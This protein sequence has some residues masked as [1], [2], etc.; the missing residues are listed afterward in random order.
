MTPIS[1]PNTPTHTTQCQAQEWEEEWK[2]ITPP[3]Q[4]PWALEEG[5]FQ[6]GKDVN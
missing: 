2:E 6:R 4:V 3:F 5:D 1:N